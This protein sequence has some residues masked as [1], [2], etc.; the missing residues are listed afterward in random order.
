MLEQDRIP[1]G[2]DMPIREALIVG[3]ACIQSL[4]P[5][6]VSV[7]LGEFHIAHNDSGTNTALTSRII[8]VLSDIA[9]RLL[10]KFRRERLFESACMSQDVL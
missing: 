9:F 6:C 4:C 3:S 10:S 8:D 2:I 1:I 7:L 5:E